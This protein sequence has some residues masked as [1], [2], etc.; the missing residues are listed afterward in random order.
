MLLWVAKHLHKL[1][2]GGNF[3]CLSRS[4]SDTLIQPSRC[5]LVDMQAVCMVKLV[6]AKNIS[7]LLLSTMYSYLFTDLNVCVCLC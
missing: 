7:Q 6:P 5:V 1:L 2:L 4:A 3:F